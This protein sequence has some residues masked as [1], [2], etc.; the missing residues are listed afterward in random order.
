MFCRN[1]FI[2]FAVFMSQVTA[3]LLSL[4]SSAPACALGRQSLREAR[5]SLLLPI[6]DV[7]FAP[8]SDYIDQPASDQV[9]GWAT[10]RKKARRPFARVVM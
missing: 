4:V 2:A 5:K 9:H 8:D 6:F 3:G 10:K 7:S 1:F